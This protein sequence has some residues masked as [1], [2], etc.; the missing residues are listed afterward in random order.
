MPVAFVAAMAASACES[1][2]RTAHCMALNGGASAIVAECGECSSSHACH[3]GAPGFPQAQRLSVAAHG[4][5]SVD[6]T[7]PP[8]DKQIAVIRRV[9]GDLTPASVC[10][11][12]FATANAATYM[13]LPS[14]FMPVVSAIPMKPR[15]AHDGVLR[16]ERSP[17]AVRTRRR[18][19]HRIR[20][21]LDSHQCAELSAFARDLAPA[22]PSIGEAKSA[23]VVV[24]RTHPVVE[25]AVRRCREHISRAWGEVHAYHELSIVRRTRGGGQ[26]LVHV[27]NS[28]ADSGARCRVPFLH[29]FFRTWSAS[30]LLS[31][32]SEFAGGELTFVDGVG[33]VNGTSTS[34]GPSADA[35]QAQEEGTQPEPGLTQGDAWLFASG[36]ENPHGVTPVERGE[37][38]VLILWLHSQ[39]FGRSSL[40][41]V[42]DQAAAGHVEGLLPGLRPHTMSAKE[43]EEFQHEDDGAHLDALYHNVT[44]GYARSEVG[45][46]FDTAESERELLP[47]IT[48]ARDELFLRLAAWK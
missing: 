16:S 20:K 38:I 21:L 6:V 34:D 24:P 30:V 11:Q 15:S 13:P 44:E 39:P 36:A 23:N 27:D 40:R 22:S 26:L 43:Q 42:S 47:S 8:P 41:A 17:L 2:C 31:T 4:A 3:P 19:R 35:D 45:A 18:R 9:L 25:Y 5:V 1:F 48:R 7:P 14:E 46:G 33:D 12:L 10:L 29:C 37:R 32:T 28:K